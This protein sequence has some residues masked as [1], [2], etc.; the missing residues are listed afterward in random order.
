MNKQGYISFCKKYEVDPTDY[1]AVLETV[2]ELE[3]MFGDTDGRLQQIREYILNN[4]VDLSTKNDEVDKSVVGL[5]EP[6][7][8]TVYQLIDGDS[9]YGKRF[10]SYNYVKNHGGISMQDYEKVAEVPVEDNVDVNVVLEDA[11]RY[12]NTNPE[13]YANNPKARSISVSD[14]LE[15]KLVKYYVD[16]MG[17]VNLDEETTLTEDK[18]LLAEK[19]EDEPPFI[20]KDEEE[21]PVEDLPETDEDKTLIDYLQ[22]RIGQQITVAEFNTILQSLFSR[23]NDIFIIESDLYNADLDENQELVINDDMEDYII[24]YDIIDVEAGII[25]I[26]DVN[27]E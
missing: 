2:D 3:G 11:F 20:E 14:I 25:E 21:I 23:Y 27:V 1:D 19:G 6:N 24:N 26:T 4:K 13:Y 15:Y 12:G 18:E 5:L 7:I 8:V 10:M 17:F 9:T 16:S 22:D